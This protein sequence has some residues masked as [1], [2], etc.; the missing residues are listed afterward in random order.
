MEPTT[1]RLD[2]RATKERTRE[3]LLDAAAAVFARRGIEAASLDEVAEAAGY[4]KGAIYSNFASKTDLVLALLERR[5]GQQAEAADAALE[6]MSLEQGLQALDEQ[7]ARSGGIDRDWIV[8]V[9]EFWLRAMR[10]EQARSAMAAQYER[11]RTLTASMLA[12][13]YAEAGEAP[14]L[15]PRELAIVIESLG[16]GVTL[17]ALLDPET[18]SVGLQAKAVSLLLGAGRAPR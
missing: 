11:A 4:T 2:R 9:V 18:I 8:L 3:R 12:R 16:I 10:D 1:P 13:K 15:P 5:I 6:G 14:P 7:A 17:Q